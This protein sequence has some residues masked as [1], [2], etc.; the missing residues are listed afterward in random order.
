[1][2][3]SL[4]INFEMGNFQKDKVK[5]NKSRELQK[6]N[7]KIIFSTHYDDEESFRMPFCKGRKTFTISQV[8]S[9]SK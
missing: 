5:H 4:S 7:R 6:K 1:M 9:F 3:E 2:I 8:R